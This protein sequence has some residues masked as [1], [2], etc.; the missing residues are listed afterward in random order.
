MNLHANNIREFIR[1]NSLLILILISS[2]ILSCYRLSDCQMTMDEFFSINIA[3]RSL[4]EIW[5]LKPHL[6]AFY[7]N[8]F[9]PLYETVLHFAWGI[10]NESL[11]WAR[12]LS[13]I[14]NAAAIIMIF[15]ISKLLFDKKT[16]FIAVSLA[17]FNYAYIFF[18]KMIRCYPLLNF[19]GLASFY[20]FFR[21]AKSKIVDNKSLVILVLINTAILYTFY[22]GG[23]V[24]LLELALSCF[25]LA[26]RALVK[27][28][29]GLLSPFVFFLPWIGHF[30]RD[31]SHE[32]AAAVHF[33]IL[34]A[35]VFLD[36]LF[37]RLQEGIFYNTG[38]LI[39][40]FAICI[41][42]VLNSIYLLFKKNNKVPFIISLLIILLP[43]IFIVSCLTSQAKELGRARYLFSF[44]FPIFIF[45]G[46]FISKLPRHIG[47]LFFLII[48]SYSIY[49]LSIYFRLPSRQFWPTAQLAPVVNEAK[50]FS[51]PYTDKVIVDIEDSLFVPIFVY[52]FYGPRYFRDA[53]IPYRGANLKQLNTALKTNYK[54][55]F[56]VA[57]KKKFHSFDSVAHL[58]DFDWFFLI[59]SN[60]LEACW[61]KPYREIYEE[62]LIEKGMQDKIILVKKES[63]GSFTLEIYKVKK[64]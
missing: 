25:F 53:S 5:S 8:S 40:Y 42:F 28:W 51:V 10:S 43:T 64:Q 16:A 32:S 55:V 18:P 1:N 44:I 54:V 9:P 21:I 6:G 20:I 46:F 4:A 47:G 26:K 13:V 59:Y 56:N 31:L 36:V 35:R 58:G 33:K 19:L 12:F 3:Q 41:Y 17:S 62:K 52:Y 27:M 34:S 15:L 22:L 11:F 45:A 61:G 38:L 57:G 23:F 63:V 14:F 30:L 50:E 49:A 24:I 2:V 60:W 48:F 37:V 39:F 7:F 29:F